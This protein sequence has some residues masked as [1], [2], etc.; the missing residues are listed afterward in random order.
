M[1]AGFHTDIQTFKEL[2]SRFSGHY[3]SKPFTENCTSH[4]TTP[5]GAWCLKSGEPPKDVRLRNKMS[6]ELPVGHVRADRGIV[7]FLMA[8]M[9][10]QQTILDLGAGVGQYGRELMAHNKTWGNQYMAFDGAVNVDKF[11]DGFVKNANLGIEQNLPVADWVLS[12]EV[13][14][15]IDHL[16]EDQYVQNLHMSNRK[17][18]ILSWAI[19]GQNGVR[20]INNH[21][22]EYIM[23][24]FKRLDYTFD[25]KT[26]TKLRADAHLPWFKHSI[27]IFRR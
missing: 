3:E 27:Y 23:N 12:L 1:I 18:I 7:H 16:M 24:R 10:T 8:L 17:G 9:R 26:T 6:Y 21:S 20:H 15:H 5:S 25:N 13:G 14:E 2:P 22:P 11:T 4:G 19:L